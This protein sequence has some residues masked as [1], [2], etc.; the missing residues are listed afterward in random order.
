MNQEQE[1]NIP[2]REANVSEYDMMETIQRKKNL[3]LVIHYKNKNF[4]QDNFFGLI[5]ICYQQT[6]KRKSVSLCDD[7][8]QPNPKKRKIVCEFMNN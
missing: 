1:A 2:T 7:E 6:P 3:L 5:R 8:E 4:L